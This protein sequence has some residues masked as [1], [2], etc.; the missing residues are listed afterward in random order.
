MLKD[1]ERL[2]WTLLAQVPGVGASSAPDRRFILCVCKRKK[3]EI[4]RP[5]K[6]RASFFFFFSFLARIRCTW[7]LQ[8]YWH[9]AFHKPPSSFWQFVCQIQKLWVHLDSKC[10]AHVC[11]YGPGDI[12]IQNMWMNWRKILNF[13]CINSIECICGIFFFVCMCKKQIR[14]RE[15]NSW[16]FIMNLE[17]ITHQNRLDPIQSCRL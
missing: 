15:K 6:E 3:K 9:S 7:E 13:L 2:L 4:V 16:G 11:I 8:S 12:C 10:S 14:K 5:L 17:E 1:Q